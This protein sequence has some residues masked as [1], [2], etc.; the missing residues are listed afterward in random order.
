MKTWLR[1]TGLTA[2]IL[3]FVG[4]PFFLPMRRRQS[5]PALRQPFSWAAV[6]TRSDM[7]THGKIV[8]ATPECMRSEETNKSG[9]DKRGR[10]LWID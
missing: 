6:K 9:V 5:S 2:N 4:N 8:A 7:P 10:Y 3:L 1:L